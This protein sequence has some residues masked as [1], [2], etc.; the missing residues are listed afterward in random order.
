M[1]TH[2]FTENTLHAWVARTAFGRNVPVRLTVAGEGPVHLD[3]ANARELTR[4]DG[5]TPFTHDD[6]AWPISYK[7]S[8]NFSMDMKLADIYKTGV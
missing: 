8:K 2:E 5:P 1:A 6:T 4:F 3:T 7:Y